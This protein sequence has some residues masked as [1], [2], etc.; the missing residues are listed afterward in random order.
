MNIVQVYSTIMT[1]TLSPRQ[2][3][4]AKETY[5]RIKFTVEKKYPG[6]FIVIDPISKEY[7]INVKLAGALRTA[8][9]RYPGR[10]FY[11]G[12]IGSEN[13]ITFS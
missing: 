10:A 7:F 12:K 8:Q 2:I 5:E 1:Q 9:D 13:V 3:A 4:E 6:Q 11:S